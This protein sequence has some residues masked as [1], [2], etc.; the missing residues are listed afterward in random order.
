MDSSIQQSIASAVMSAVTTAV[1]AIQTKHESE[2]LSL[3]KMIE[4]SLLLRDSPSTT[5]PPD[6]DASAKLSTPPDN[7]TKTVERWNQANLGYFDPHLDKTHGEGEVV[8]V[9]KDVYYRN[10]VLFVQRLQSLVTFKGAAL[11]KANVATSLRSSALEWY[12]SELSDFDRDALNND[13]SV[14][15]W[16]ST[17]SN[18]FK[19]PTSVAL[20]LLTDETYLLDNARTRR[21]PTQYV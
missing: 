2:M 7:S 13:P 10:V 6:P 15:S 19:V 9:G 11:V 8:S 5:P 16:I 18:R 17:L 21:P 20:G 3:R 14:K 4:K 1:A 12:T